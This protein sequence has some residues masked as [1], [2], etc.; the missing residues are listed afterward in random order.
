MNKTFK[1]KAN[2]KSVHQYSQNRLSGEHWDRTM[3]IRLGRV[4]TYPRFILY[5]VSNW[6]QKYDIHLRALPT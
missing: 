4:S 6:D 1:I 5:I 3:S 2:T